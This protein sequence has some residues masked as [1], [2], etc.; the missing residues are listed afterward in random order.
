MTETFDLIT[1]LTT[2][3]GAH[4]DELVS[5]DYAIIVNDTYD[6]LGYDPSGYDEVPSYEAQRTVGMMEFW[7]RD[8]SIVVADKEAYA[9]AKNMYEIF[10]ARAFQYLVVGETGSIRSIKLRSKHYHQGDYYFDEVD[11]FDPYNPVL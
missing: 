4:F 5:A 11:Y 2:Y 9:R 7:L 6:A 3:A 1:F 10:L 8:M